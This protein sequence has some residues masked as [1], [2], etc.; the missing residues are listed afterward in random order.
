MD[1]LRVPSRATNVVI[2]VSDPSTEYEYTILDDVD[3]SIIEGT[4]TSDSN[5]KVTITLPSEYDNSYTVTV[6]G[7]EHFL[8]VTRPY[9]DP[10]TKGTTAS[11]IA[12]YSKNEEIARAIIDSIVDDGFYYR[13]RYIETVGLGSDYI[14]VWKRAQKVL[15]LY[16]NNVLMYDALNPED[17]AIVYTLTSDKSAIIQAYS[18]RINRAEGAQL[19]FPEA[20][21][22][23]LDTQYIYRG[24]PRTF[25]YRILITHGYKTVPSEIARAT[26]LLVDDI[27]CGK[28]EYYQ[29]YITE[30][31]TD[32]YQVKM[33]QAALS[34]TGNIIVDKILSNYA[35]PFKTPGVL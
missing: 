21:S 35:R 31:R 27:A 8:N 16:E 2:N 20:A 9:V 5:S 7:E 33:N 6:D 15:R 4:V 3:H 1:I 23:L 26:E 10:T 11:E 12:E 17:Y 30:Y 28:M 25:D 32:Q 14:P 29:R 24:F 18:D 34:G 13:K 19:I 22:D